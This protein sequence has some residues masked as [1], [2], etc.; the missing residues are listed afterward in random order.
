MKNPRRH[1]AGI[2][3]TATVVGFL[4]LDFMLVVPTPVLD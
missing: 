1:C 4:A 3:I 2:A